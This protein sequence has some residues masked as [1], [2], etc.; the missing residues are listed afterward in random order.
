MG[1]EIILQFNF[2]GDYLANGA[3]VYSLG[4]DGHPVF[5]GHV[6]TWTRGMKT[7]HYSVLNF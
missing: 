3:V 4:K 2:D 1:S 5:I 6:V 7:A